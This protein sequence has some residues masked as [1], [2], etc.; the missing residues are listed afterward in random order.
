MP[1]SARP[2]T[3]E[4][5]IL[6]VKPEAV[7]EP[8][9]VEEAAQ[10]VRDCARDK[11]RL[12][13]VG[14]GT[15]LAL[16]AP[17]LALDVVLKTTRMSRVIEHAPSDQI[18]VAEAGL[19]LAPLQATLAFHRQRLALDPPLPSRATLGGIVAAN[20]FGPRRARYGSA[21]DMI[22]GISIIRS[23]GT[24]ARGGGKVVKNVAGFDLQKLMV[25][26]LGTLG[27]IATVTFRLHPL[28]EESVTLLLSGRDARQV[29]ALVA[30]IREKQ[31]EPTSVV[32]V[33]RGTGGLDIAVRFEGFRAG[34][35]EQADRLR[36]LLAESGGS[37]EVLSPTAAIS[38][39]EEHDSLRTAAPL[40]A[41]LTVLPS[42]IE[43]LVNEALPPLLAVLERPALVWYATLGIGFVSGVPREPGAVATAIE[44]VRA[45]LAGGGGTLTLQAAPG[46]VRERA[47]VWGAS[48][49]ALGLMQSVKDRL[50]PE[51]RL[52]PGRFVGG[53]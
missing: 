33:W 10:V 43:S 3:V 53:I 20:S 41:K 47:P 28:P 46:A 30:S 24:L 40:L 16:G 35:T 8:S 4:D 36:S 27:L 50:D 39:W 9:T 13:F 29:R 19:T 48:P 25:G 17:P 34:V 22:I 52:A 44:T 38:F 26:S 7:F 5:A 21:R 31:L 11:K 14:G 49:A 42:S 2:A 51:R 12:A 45:R 32:A 6:G 1:A 23:D 15:E 37:S 18:V